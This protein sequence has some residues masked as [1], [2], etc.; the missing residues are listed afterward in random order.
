MKRLITYI[1]KYNLIFNILEKVV[2]SI[3]WLRDN[4]INRI[5][6]NIYCKKEIENNKIVICS[7]YGRG[8][9]DNSK[10]IV[11]EIIKKNLDY[12]IV[13]IVNDISKNESFPKN[14]K[15]IKYKSK[16]MIYELATAKIWIDNSRKQHY[17][18]K[19]ENQI[20]IQTWHGGVAL[21]KIEKD[22]INTLS[23][24]YI[25]FAKKDS[26][27]IDLFISNSKFISNL[28]KST[29]WYNGDILEVGVPRN[30]ILF[31]EADILE[32]K[33]KHSLKIP[34]DKRI[35][36]YAPT[37]RNDSNIDVYKFDYEKVIDTFNKKFSKEHILIIRL[38][39]NILKKST[40]LGLECFENVYNGSFYPDMQELLVVSDI[41]ITD[42]SSSMFDFML[43]QKPCFI[44]ATDIESYRDERGFYFDFK[45]LPFDIATNEIELIKSVENFKQDK[46]SQNI[47]E[48]SKDIGIIDNGSASAKVVD[49][50]ENNK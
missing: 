16:E 48:F 42:Y 28:C 8:Y 47:G 27:N 22:A 17:T 11:D 46:Y 33:I 6:W 14:I 35:I 20:Y 19:R 9:S 31:K 50:I 23:K 37:F 44:Y 32:K 41:L 43:T 15:T 26:E 49:W 25:K 4:T 1:K 21:K 10:Y 36:M 24:S 7:Y 5:Y 3:L 45:E 40:E 38:H 34:K 13:W 30:D 12:K 39:P 2:D 18:K 29:F